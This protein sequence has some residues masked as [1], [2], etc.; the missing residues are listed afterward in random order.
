MRVTRKIFE[1]IVAEA[2]AGIPERFRLRLQNVAILVESEPSESLLD[3]CEVPDGETMYG[4][5][6]GTPLTDRD[7][8]GE[9][10]LPDR[11]IIFQRPIEED[12]EAMEE[13]RAETTATI[14]HEIAHHFG[15][16][17]DRLEELGKY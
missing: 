16:E 3:E 4:Y 13:L 17:D 9:P 6:E 10:M 8:N 1:E 15:I 2:V 7:L 5:Y 12:C 11:I 14:R